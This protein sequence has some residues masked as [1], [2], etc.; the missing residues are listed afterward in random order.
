MRS[1]FIPPPLL[2]YLCYF[3]KQLFKDLEAKKA[4][5][6]G[7]KVTFVAFEKGISEE[8][9]RLHTTREENHK[10][11]SAAKDKGDDVAKNH[12]RGL[13]DAANK[14]VTE[15][16]LNHEAAKQNHETSRKL[17]ESEIEE[18]TRSET[19]NREKWYESV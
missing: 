15:L 1:P 13:R 19:I 4:E 5:L 12:H 14:K 16:V 11:Q 6:E 10:L 3:S 9:S 17:L 8:Y 2:L 7:E 18:L